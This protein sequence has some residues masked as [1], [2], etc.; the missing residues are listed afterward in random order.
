M[1][2]SLPRLF[3]LQFEGAAALLLNKASIDTQLIHQYLISHR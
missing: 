1:S 2:A 3:W